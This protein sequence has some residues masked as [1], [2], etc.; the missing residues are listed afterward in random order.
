MNIII[1]MKQSNQNSIEHYQQ[2]QHQHQTRQ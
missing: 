1:A 2:Q